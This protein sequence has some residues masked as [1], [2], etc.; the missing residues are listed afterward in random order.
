MCLP[1]GTSGLQPL[2]ISRLLVALSDKEFASV[3]SN[4]LRTTD[5][6]L[7]EALPGQR[8]VA[9]VEWTVHV[10]NRKGSFFQFNGAKG[11]NGD[12]SK[13]G[14][15]NATVSGNDARSGLE[16]DPGPKPISGLSAGPVSLGESKSHDLT[17]WI[18]KDLGDISTDF[19]VLDA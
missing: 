2:T 19:A 9:A 15:R 16:I 18:I 7:G 5:P 12:F 8:D 17:N 4:S 3:S 13:N 1:I 6:R 14:A 10:A 11:E